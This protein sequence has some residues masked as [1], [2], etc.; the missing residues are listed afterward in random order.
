MKRPS[1]WVRPVVAALAVVLAGCSAADPGS[2]TRGLS[3]EVWDRGLEN[4]AVLYRVE[5]DGTISFGGGRDA[6]QQSVS[7][8]GPLTAEEIDQLWVLLED[9]GWFSGEVRAASTGEPRRRQCWIRLRWPGG[10]K[11]IRFRGE[12]PD[13]DPVEALLA[14]ASRRRLQ[15]DL[16]TLPQPSGQSGSD[17]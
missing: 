6:I 13:V 1:R 15:G 17:R 5:T 16:K 7:W 10:K 2:A 8:T 11:R 4:R 14:E 12:N 9:H 3:L